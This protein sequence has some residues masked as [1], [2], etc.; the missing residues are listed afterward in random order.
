[1]K[2]IRHSQLLALRAT[3]SNGALSADALPLRIKL[4][5]WGS[6]PS[7]KGDIK[8]GSKTL[9]A[10]PSNQAKHGYDRV[11]IDYEHQSV[12]QHPNFQEPPRQ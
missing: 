3:I 8:V 5:N 1:M 11:G 6:N 12:P 9:A 4:L 2:R 7:L 10:L